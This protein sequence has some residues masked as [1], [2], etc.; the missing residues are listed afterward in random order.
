[1]K[2]WYLSK[3]VY[4]FPRKDVVALY[5]ALRIK[6]VYLQPDVYEKVMLFSGGLTVRKFMSLI[7][8]SEKGEYRRLLR[9]LKRFDFILSNQQEDDDVFKDVAKS[10]TDPYPHIMYLMMSDACNLACRYCFEGMNRCTEVKSGRKKLMDRNTLLAALDC[11]ARIIAR[12]PEIFNQEKKI[13]FYGGEP[14]LNLKNI[15]LALETISAY[16]DSGLLPRN[17]KFSIITNGT[18]L[19]QKMIKIFKRYKVDVSVSLDGGRAENK[20]RVFVDGREA[21]D[22]IIPA[23]ERCIAGGVGTSISCTLNEN[24]INSFSGVMEAIER[25]GVKFV[26]FNMLLGQNSEEYFYK[27]SRF[28]I[29][30]FEVFRGKRCLGGS[31][32]SQAKSFF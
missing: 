21:Y 7:P 6:P 29:K 10:I 3:F 25:S 19:S 20:S 9:Q 22:F 8:D 11:Y 16:Q 12:R 18:L 26:G 27:A 5:Q 31:R 1:M 23:L 13:I 30:A 4:A 32:L 14:L 28:I 15:L 2:T 24:N 17:I